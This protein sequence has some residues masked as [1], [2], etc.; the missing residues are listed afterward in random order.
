MNSYIQDEMMDVRNK[1]D[2]EDTISFQLGHD[3]QIIR[4]PD[5]QYECWIDGQCYV[6][7]LTHLGALTYGMIQYNNTRP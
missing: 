6:T 7:A 1:F 5:F 3:V 4:G 2:L